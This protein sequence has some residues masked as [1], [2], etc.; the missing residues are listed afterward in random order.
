MLGCS[1]MFNYDCMSYAFIGIF[2]L[3]AKLPIY[4]VHLAK[5]AANTVQKINPATKRA[6]IKIVMFSLA[7]FRFFAL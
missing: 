5:S 7:R 6:F 4:Y 1:G 2:N 3:H